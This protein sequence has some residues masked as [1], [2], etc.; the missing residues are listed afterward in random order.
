MD[1]F[2]IHGIKVEKVNTIFRYDKRQMITILLRF[3]ELCVILILLSRSSIQ[4]PFAFKLS[5]EYFRGLFITLIS[6]RF[7]F[8]I[9]NAIIVILF[10]KS[11]QLSTK[12]GE[13][14]SKIGVY[15]EYMENCRKKN[16]E[17]Q[18]PT[19]NITCCDH[20]K[21]KIHRSQSEKME[22]MHCE[23][24]HWELRRS[25]TERCQ[26]SVN[27]VKKPGGSSCAK[28]KMSSEEFRRTVED[29]IARQQ[30]SLREG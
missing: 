6:P 11:G 21:R 19:N 5:D 2:N 12:D 24:P 7:V 28:D 16:I 3:M 14:H 17:N 23:D 4:L 20:K 25:M 18:K 15:D 10:M 27:C 30:R 1:S 13:K 8:V 9:G 22:R 26:K 29:F